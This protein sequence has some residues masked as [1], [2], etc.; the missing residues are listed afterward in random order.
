VETTAHDRR[1]FQLKI[2]LGAALALIAYCA[3][4]GRIDAWIGWGFAAFL[5]AALSA[6]YLILVRVAPDL[7]VERVSWGPASGAMPA[8]KPIVTWLALAPLA[9]CLAAGLDARFHGVDADPVKIAFGYVLGGLGS[10]L[11]NWAM[12]TNRFYAPTVR[13][14]KERGH[15]TVE[16]GPYAIVRHPGNLGNV[17]LNLGRPSARRPT[18]ISLLGW[19]WNETAGS[20]NRSALPLPVTM[21]SPGAS[22]WPG[23]TLT[24][25]E[26]RSTRISWPS[27]ASGDKAQS[28]NGANRIAVPPGEIGARYR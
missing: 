6:G 26:T 3:G 20:I 28:R 22:T 16:S 4:R 11:T 24:G 14:Q 12:A 25:P 1:L 21:R 7:I 15:K 2:A 27:A 17:L 8:D 18:A 13:I 9:A 23:L 5:L 19:T 10:A